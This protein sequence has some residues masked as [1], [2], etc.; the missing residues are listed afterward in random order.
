MPAD[1]FFARSRQTTR[2][3]LESAGA[4][5]DTSSPYPSALPKEFILMKEAFHKSIAAGDLQGFVCQFLE[6][7]FPI[8]QLLRYFL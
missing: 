2:E 6:L 1:T 3:P 4:Q 8:F 5:G 7:P